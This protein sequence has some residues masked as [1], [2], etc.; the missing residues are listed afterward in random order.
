M[1]ELNAKELEEYYKENSGCEGVGHLRF[2]LMIFVC[3]WAFTIPEPTGILTAISGFAIPCFFLLSGYFVL[4]EEKGK[5]EIKIAGKLARTLRCLAFVFVFYMII[6]VALLL[7]THTGVTISKR[8][9]FNFVV[10]NLWPLPVGT[11]FW[12]LQAMAYAYLILFVAEKLNLLRFYKVALV[13]LM[14]LMLL[15]GEFAGIIHFNFLKYTYIPGNWLTRA[16]P[17]LLLGMFLREKKSILFRI[18]TWVYVALLI[19]GAALVVGELIL[20]GIN[21]VLVYEGH[22][23]GYGI[24]AVA[25][26]GLA[27]RNPQAIVTPASFYDTAFS[28]II[29]IFMEPVYYMLAFGLGLINANAPAMF[30]AYAGG[31]VAMILSMVLAL[32]LKGTILSAAFFSNY[33]L[34]NMQKEDIAAKA[35]G[36][37]YEEL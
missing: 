17:Y 1:E 11:N 7:V 34:K 9:I 20:L 36:E 10:L 24:M 6:N 33:H 15:T 5:R 16:L 12:F 30:M 25:A 22:M 35:L 21:G 4:T 37:S 14:I 27:I 13:L 8:L 2:I 3:F 31:V 29:Y 28:G 23:I 32:I 18:R 26:L 19:L